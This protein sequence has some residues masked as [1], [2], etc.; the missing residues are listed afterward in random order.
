M[1][2]EVMKRSIEHGH[3]ISRINV[4]FKASESKNAATI[5]RVRSPQPRLFRFYY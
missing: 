3:V 5:L 2:L 4:R 1:K